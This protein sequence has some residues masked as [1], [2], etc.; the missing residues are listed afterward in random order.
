MP[1]AVTVRLLSLFFPVQATGSV[2]PDV[3]D[4]D[5]DVVGEPL[6]DGDTDP[7]GDADSD[8]GAE[9]DGDGDADSPAVEADGLGDSVAYA[10]VVATAPDSSAAGSSAAATA[11]A[12][13]ARA[14]RDFMKG[15][16]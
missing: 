2:G 4:G 10:V 12:G 11:R 16:R 7:D 6:A 8:S 3:G 14:R 9:P 1:E 5:A 15:P 13:R